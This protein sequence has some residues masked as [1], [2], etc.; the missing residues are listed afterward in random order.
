M[1]NRSAEHFSYE[2]IARLVEPGSSVL[3]LGCGNGELLQLLRDTRNAT[4]R[5]VDIEESM[6]RECL[7]KGISVF[8]GNLDEGLK[9]YRSGSYDYVILNET[10]QVVHEPVQLIRE[11]VRVGRTA[12]VNF[13]NFGNIVNRM[14]LLIGGRMPVNQDLPYQWYDTPNIHF[15]TRRDFVRLCR[16]MEIPII[17]TVDMRHGRRISSKAANLSATECCFLLKGFS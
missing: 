4:V 10:L 2:E 13:P 14:Q 5:G 15:C 12:I 3:D 8:Q 9:E 16:E 11:M 1:F 17:A 6:I 7:A